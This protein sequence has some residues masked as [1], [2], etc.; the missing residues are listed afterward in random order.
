MDTQWSPV[1][2]GHALPV[3]FRGQPERH[4]VH[5]TLFLNTPGR[6]HANSL[7]RTSCELRLRMEA[8]DAVRQQETRFGQFPLRRHP[9]S[10]RKSSLVFAQLKR[11][12]SDRDV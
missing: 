11:R 3:E 4:L 12:C 5:E 1:Q 2:I 6:E 9:R 10:V 7:D 8:A